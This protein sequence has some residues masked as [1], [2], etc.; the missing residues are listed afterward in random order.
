[1]KKLLILLSIFSV[2][3]CL[4]A[5]DIE[6]DGCPKEVTSQAESESVSIKK[7]S[8]YT[9]A[10]SETESSEP[11]PPTVSKIEIHKNPDKMDYTKTDNRFDSTG[12]QLKIF[13]SNG[14]TEIIDKGFVCYPIVLTSSNRVTIDYQGKTVALLV[15]LTD[16]REE[17]KIP[18]IIGVSLSKV[19][20]LLSSSNIQYELVYNEVAYLSKDKKKPVPSVTHYEKHRRNEKS[21]YDYLYD[22]EVLEVHINAPAIYIKNVYHEIDYAN[23]VDLNIELVN[24]SNKT[25]KYIYFY[26]VEFYNAVAD[27]AYCSILNTYKRSLNCTGPIYSGEKKESYWADLIY[28]GQVSAVKIPT[29]AVEFMD[30]TYQIIEYNVLWYDDRYYIGDKN[31]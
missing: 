31:N 18:D 5:C 22:G 23:G 6:K 21:G 10:S 29:I 25:I 8:E 9:T 2:M 28:N 27:P 30:G 19:E 4:A 3:L 7:P 15:N 12:L 20:K 1:M 24:C 26:D 11:E 16:G 14:E 17:I 13:Y